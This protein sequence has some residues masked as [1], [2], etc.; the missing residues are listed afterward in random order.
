[1]NYHNLTYPDML[2]GDGLRV[3]LWLSGCSHH[4]NKCQNPQTWSIHSG[5]PFDESAE[6]E[7][8]EE[9]S[10]DYISG[11]TFSGGDPLQEN[12]LD[13]VLRLVNKIR[14]L[15][16]NKTI[17][18]YTGYKW[19]GILN[20]VIT[21]NF[22]ITK[23]EI[24]NKRIEIVKSCDIVVDG[25]YIDELRDVSL[26]WRGSSNQRVIDVKQTLEKGELTLWCQ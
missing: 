15:F 26:M 13:E 2:N 1:M 3:V 12:N 11:V 14:V 16:P 6:K 20:P 4:C 8:F 24:I 18:L 9:S 7:F 23:D 19:E 17:W 5:I 22:D 21:D 25:K 10:K